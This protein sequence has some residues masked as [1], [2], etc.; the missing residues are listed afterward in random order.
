M[1]YYKEVRTQKEKEKIRLITIDRNTHLNLVV[2][3]DSGLINAVVS[4]SPEQAKELRN[5]LIEAYP[6]QPEPSEY[7]VR[8]SDNYFVVYRKEPTFAERVIAEVSL[9]E[10][11]KKI[12]QA[13]NEA[14]GL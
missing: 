10:A 3:T 13:L 5:A 7:K 9:E 11:A 1:S 4:L 6:L 8:A 12:A 2:L 14:E